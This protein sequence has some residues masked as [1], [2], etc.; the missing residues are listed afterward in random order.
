MSICVLVIL[1][2]THSYGIGVNFNPLEVAHISHQIK[3]GQ[4]EGVFTLAS[5]VEAPSHHTTS[6]EKTL[7]FDE[8][9]DLERLGL[10]E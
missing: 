3:M 2:L 7:G 4:L 10:F 1:H 9:S 6:Q 8:A 5:F